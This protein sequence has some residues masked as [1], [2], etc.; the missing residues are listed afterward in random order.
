MTGAVRQ[1]QDGCPRG[2]WLWAEGVCF[3]EISEISE[4]AWARLLLGG[5]VMRRALAASVLALERLLFVRLREGG[6]VEALCVGFCG[7]GPVW[8][9]TLGGASLMWGNG[10][11]DSR[12][13]AQFWALKGSVVGWPAKLWSGFVPESEVVEQPL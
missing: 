7:E 12:L 5:E 11:C 2:W 13:N 10:G 3:G 6:C 8:C 9:G 1:V 4:G